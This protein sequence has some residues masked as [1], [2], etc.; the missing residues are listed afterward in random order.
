[1][2]SLEVFEVLTG[3]RVD[4]SKFFGVGAGV[5]KCGAGAESES[6]KCDSTHLELDKA[7]TLLFH[8]SAMQ[9][10]KGNVV[11]CSKPPTLETDLQ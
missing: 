8:N 5:L 9:H 6:E 1:M 2:S 11:A 3:V 4:V 10:F 7:G